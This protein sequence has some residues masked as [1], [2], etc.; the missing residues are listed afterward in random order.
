MN[1]LHSI[2]G[3]GWIWL[4]LKLI[5][6]NDLHTLYSRGMQV[7]CSQLSTDVGERSTT[8]YPQSTI[9]WG[10]GDQWVGIV[11]PSPIVQ[12]RLGCRKAP[13]HK[14][15]CTDPFTNPGDLENKKE[16]KGKNNKKKLCDHINMSHPY[17]HGIGVFQATLRWYACSVHSNP[18]W[19][20]QICS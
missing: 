3:C 13:T 15:H 5:Q 2:D 17:R 14:I 9:E 7:C 1:E 20:H 10:G 11:N 8:S 12:G 16:R 4:K 18:Q 19:P 6:V